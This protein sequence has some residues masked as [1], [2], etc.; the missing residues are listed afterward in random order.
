MSL[1]VN[2]Y[3]VKRIYLGIYNN[4]WNEF[5]YFKILLSLIYGDLRSLLSVI[6]YM[7]GLSRK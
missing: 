7:V 4:V 3:L 1:R 5:I 2:E 6:D